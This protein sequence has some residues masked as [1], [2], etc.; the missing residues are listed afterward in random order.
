M[1]LARTQ[2]SQLLKGRF[3]EIEAIWDTDP[4]NEVLV[5]ALTIK[6][7]MLAHRLHEVEQGID[8]YLDFKQQQQRELAPLGL[9]VSPALDAPA[10]PARLVLDLES[11]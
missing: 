10:V 3:D 7:F 1:R 4:Y 11:A 5:L 9:G 2:V 8:R 6:E